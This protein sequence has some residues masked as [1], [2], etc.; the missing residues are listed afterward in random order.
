[1]AGVPRNRAQT[2]ETAFDGRP[3]PAPALFDRAALA[4]RPFT[5]CRDAC[6][7]VSPIRS[8][9]PQAARDTHGVAGRGAIPREVG[10]L[11]GGISPMHR[12]ICRLR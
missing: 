2:P 1:M 7:T 3:A 10:R 4:R 5:D 9:T 12:V 11:W 6:R 8:G